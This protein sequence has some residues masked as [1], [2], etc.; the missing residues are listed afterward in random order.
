M[1]IEIDKRAIR[2]PDGA[3][4]IIEY[5]INV[6]YHLPKQYKNLEKA[7]INVRK[8]L[9]DIL[10]FCQDNDP[11]IWHQKYVWFIDNDRL[12][13]VVRKRTTYSTSNKHFNYL[14]CIGALNKLKQT[15]NNMTG[16]SA[17]FLLNEREKGKIRPPNTFTVY[18]Y[19]SKK[20]AEMDGRAAQLLEHKIT[21]GN[22]SNDKLKASGCQELAEEVFYAN[23]ETSIQ[24]KTRKFKK[25]L[26]QILR[27]CD[28]KGY[29]DKKELCSSLG[30]S[31]NR[32]DKFLNVFKEQWQQEYQYKAP[33]KQ[34]TEKYN[35]KSKSWIITRR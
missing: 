23:S 16:V 32:L 24:N 8:D 6:L 12:T 26:E 21:S 29:T 18:R 34:E 1:C 28:H 5:N 15:E 22:I 14:C 25:V 20:L 4:E 31:R 35:L 3:R 27:L 30:W 19:T 33:N 7:L 11:I 17:T 2:T 9:Y 13:E 10:H